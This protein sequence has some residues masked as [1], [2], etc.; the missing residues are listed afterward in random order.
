VKNATEP[1]KYFDGHGLYLQVDP[2]GSRFWV[3]HITNRGKRTGLRLTVACF[4][5]RS[6][7]GGTGKP[8][9]GASWRRPDAGPPITSSGCGKWPSDRISR[10][11]PG[12]SPSAS[13]STRPLTGLGRVT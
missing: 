8:Q 9:A 5:V 10:P 11:A 4:A 12:R 3:Q 13:W 7:H 1:R 2:N 6:A